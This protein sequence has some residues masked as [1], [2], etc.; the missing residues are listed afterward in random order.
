M[1]YE[2]TFHNLWKSDNPIDKP[3]E[4]IEKLPNELY[5]L[6]IDELAILAEDPFNYKKSHLLR[7]PWSVFYSWYPNKESKLKNYRIIYYVSKLI[8][9]IR[10][11]QHS[12]VYKRRFIK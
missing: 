8:I 12:E 3:E 11:G 2:I 5:N 6:L 1:V 9:I 7:P 10:I 4:Y